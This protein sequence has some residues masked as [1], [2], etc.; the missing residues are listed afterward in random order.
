MPS[1]P[2]IAVK[3]NPKL[4]AKAKAK[5]CT[6]GGLC[7]HSARKMQWAV[8]YYNTHGGTYVGKKSQRNSMRKW[9]KER[10]RTSDGRNSAGQR[11]YLPDKAWKHLTPD[12]VRRTNES[13]RRGTRKGKQW[14]AQP[15]DVRRSLRRGR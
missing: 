7:P 11:R 6:Q 12:Q 8:R 5:A 10:W 3:A 14:V 13:K 9:T 15:K 1:S 2:R 4:W